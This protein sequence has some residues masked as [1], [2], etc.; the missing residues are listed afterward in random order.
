MAVLGFIDGLGDAVVSISQAVSGYFA[1]KTQ[2]RKPFIW[3]GYIFAG[4]ARVGYAFSPV[5]HY[6]IPFRVID[7]M[8][9]MRGSPRDAIIADVSTDQNRGRN[10]GFLKMMDNLGAVCGVIFTIIFFKYLGY[11]KIFIIA[12]IPSIF[13]AALVFWFIKDGAKDRKIFKGITFKDFH[14]DLILYM[15]L[16]ALFAISSFSYSFLLIFATG[17][18]PH[19]IN[20]DHSLLRAIYLF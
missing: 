11:T 19:D 12:A 16:S 9:K 5:W 20:P 3:I 18:L 14:R 1:D 6:I 8:G 13:A 7:R 17:K 4:I 15:V 10:F 2:K